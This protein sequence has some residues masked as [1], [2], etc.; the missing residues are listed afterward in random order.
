[1]PDIIFGQAAIQRNYEHAKTRENQL[2]E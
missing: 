2:N 1:M